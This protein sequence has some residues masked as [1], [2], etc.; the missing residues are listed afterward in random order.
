MRHLLHLMCDRCRISILVRIVAIPTTAPPPENPSPIRNN[1]AAAAPPS[2]CP[3]PE[4]RSAIQSSIGEILQRI[5]A[6][7]ID[8]RRAGLLLYNLRIASLNLPKTQPLAK[9]AAEPQTVEEIIID[10]LSA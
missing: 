10:P 4:D 6:N 5:A 9:A 8:P 2:T 3:C 7:D 1:A